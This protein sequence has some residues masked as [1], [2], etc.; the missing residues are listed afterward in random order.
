MSFSNY[1]RGPT[2]SL[3]DQI[4]SYATTRVPDSQR[5]RR[6]AIL[7]VLTGN[8]TAMFWFALG[9]QMGFLVGWPM[10]LLPIA[11]M[12]VGATVVGALVM[13]IASQEGLSLPL[14]SR[15]LGFGG[16]GSA[17]ASF[18]YA[19]NYIFYFIFEGSIVSHGLS[20]IAGISINSAGASV[21]FGIV[22]LVA[23]YCSWRG[24]HS[25]N[26]LQRYGMPIFLVL[27]VIGM[28]MLAN[29]YVLVGPGDWVVQDG[30]SAT[31]MWQALSLANGQVV[32]Q[33]LIATDYGR[34]VKRSVSYV[35]TGGVML[36][37]LLMIAGVMILGVFLGFTMINHFDGTR[38]EQEL[39]ATDPGLIFA[40]VM[41]VL[42]VVF[43]ILTQVRIN[44]M[45]LYSG[46]LA[47]SNAWDV[48]SV[49]R[50]GRQWWM[51]LLVGIGILLYPINVLQYTDKFLAVTGVM[52]NTWIFILLSDYFV[53][54]KLLKL[55]PVSNIEYREGLVKDW[56]LCGMAAL[57]VGVT[58]GALGVLGVYPMHFASF[59]AMVAG[60]L[61]Y[62]PLTILTRGSQ[63]GSTVA[64][65]SGGA[66]D[67][68][69]GVAE[70]TDLRA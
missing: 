41:G 2:T 61:V 48:L 57:A 13:R 31:A 8:V 51:V 29:G 33:A 35:G 65:T 23:L 5:W 30:V 40:I 58:I 28:V 9:G 68:Q 39:A 22:A 46:S 50:V 53:C 52:T 44:V 56:N 20:E 36:V 38:A 3:D 67:E 4:E 15:G 25:M 59:A 69:V 26:I 60:P 10:V 12:I 64:V 19:V 32:F 62:I 11:Y 55:A 43:A 21:V 6:P 70:A 1:F 7:L 17:I 16:R 42:G 27:F 18:V 49:R 45:N 14:L 66:L 63:Y 47:L 37:E 34:F 54:R 24:M